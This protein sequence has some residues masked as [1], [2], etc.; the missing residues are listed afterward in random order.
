MASGWDC[1]VPD[2]GLPEKVLPEGRGVYA[3]AVGGAVTRARAHAGNRSPV[4]LMPLVAY[5]GSRHAHLAAAEMMQPTA[6][7]RNRRD[8]RRGQETRS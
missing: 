5:P 7:R 3:A 4:R 1:D 6:S 8:L 2:T